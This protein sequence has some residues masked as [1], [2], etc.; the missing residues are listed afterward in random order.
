MDT[1]TAT[2][3]A[4]A[5]RSL[6]S[7]LLS[8]FTAPGQLFADFREE[9]PPWV[10]PLLISIVVTAAVFLLMPH[11]AFVEQARE[12][13]RQRGV[14]GGPDPEA[15][16]RLSPIFAAVG[17]AISL[18]IMLLVLSG[19]LTL[20]FS[21]LMGGE[22]RFRQYLAVVSHATLITALGALLTL[23]LQVMKADLSVRL[24][25]ALF[26]PFLAADSFGFKLLNSLD[27]FLIWNL[28][29]VGLGVHVLNGRRIGWASATGV[30]FAIFLVLTGGVLWVTT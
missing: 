16:A 15:M 30:L 22:A 25:L 9:S 11:E 2:A 3:P 24:S 27:V 7:R 6:P 14:A 17:T 4:A 26:A 21:V 20:V 12:T 8:V 18:P 10:T 1:I 29:V 23:P 28:V 19:V 13:M 5:P